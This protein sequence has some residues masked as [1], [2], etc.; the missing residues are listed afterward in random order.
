V[1]A[2]AE[3][4]RL[5]MASQGAFSPA[6][7]RKG[8]R[9][10]FSRLMSDDDIWRLQGEGKPQPFLVST[11]HDSSSQ[12]STDGQRVAFA[13]AR[14]VEGI[15]IWLANAD[16]SGVAQLTRGPEG[17][18]G[19]PRWSPDGRSIA[20]DAQGKEGRRN[21]KVVDSG[22]GQP[23]QLTDGPFSSAVPSWSRDGK[24]IYF[25]SDRGGRFEIWKAPAQGGAAAQITQEGGYVALESADAKTLYYTKSSGG[26]GPLYARL[27]A[28]GGE[29]QILERVSSRGFVVFEDGIYYLVRTGQRNYEIRFY[30]FATGHSRMVSAFEGRLNLGLSVSPDRKTFLFTWVVSSGSDLMLIENFR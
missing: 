3:P 4:Q 9:L 30:V 13:S 26:D 20:F 19:S 22:G 10:A 11:M 18:H 8:N 15:A 6:V 5:E 28:G 27:L 29:K 17:Y 24:S 23:R 12:F 7:A 25:T 16:G 14:G 1:A 2:G 21:I